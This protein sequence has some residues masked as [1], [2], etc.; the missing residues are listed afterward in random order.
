MKRNSQLSGVLHV[1]LHMAEREG[2]TTSERLAQALDT[3]PVVVRRLMAGLRDKGYVRSERGHGG[4]WVLARRLSDVTLRDIYTALECSPLIAIG[5][6]TE[7]PGCVIEQAVNGALDRALV[8]AEALLLERFGAMTLASLRTRV[9]RRL[10][11]SGKGRRLEV[12]HAH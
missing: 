11:A 4:G 6:R 9:Q 8:E 2:P 3:N 5:N 7:S 10:R 1:L 12:A